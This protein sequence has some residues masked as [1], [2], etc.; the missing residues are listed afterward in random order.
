[1]RSWIYLTIE[2]ESAKKRSDCYHTVAFE[3][4]IVYMSVCDKHFYDFHH[5]FKIAN[6]FNVFVLY[7]VVFHLPISHTHSTSTISIE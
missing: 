2:N 6:L 1:M 3:M 5:P 7:I 4:C